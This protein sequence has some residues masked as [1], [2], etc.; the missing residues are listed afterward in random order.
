MKIVKK[1]LI[2]IL[3]LMISVICF[4]T[5]N[6]I[7]SLVSNYAAVT[8]TT[9]SCIPMVMFLAEIITFCFGYFNYTV[10][11]KKDIYFFRNYSLIMGSFALVGFIFSIIAG[12]KIY[13]TF[14]GDYVF[15]AYPLIMLIVHSLLLVLCGIKAFFTIREIAKYSPEREWKNPQLYW[16]REIFIVVIFTFSLER[17]GAFVLLPTYFSSYDGIYVLP[18]YIQLL[19]PTLAF[20]TYLIHE[21]WLHNRKVTII[22]SSIAFGYTLFSFIYMLIIASGSYPL[23]IN[24]LSPIMQL[25]RLTIYP[26][27]FVILYL[28]SFLIPGLNLGNNI[29]MTIK[30]KRKSSK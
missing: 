20:S 18:I 2:A 10:I 22:L 7:F 26:I 4:Y 30:E 12:T 17:L 3:I 24:P 1:I 16:V 13:H 15:N 28:F 29:V 27:G 6:L 11:K 8:A 9:M 23:V 21:Y 25:E 14:T 19:V 5:C